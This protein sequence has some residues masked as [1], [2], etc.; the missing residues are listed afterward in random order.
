VIT[1][2]MTFNV[3][4]RRASRPIFAGFE[5]DLPF[6]VFFSAITPL[7]KI[8]YFFFFNSLLIFILIIY[9]KIRE[10]PHFESMRLCRTL[11]K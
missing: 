1:R 10:E 11:S 8:L 5:A 7:V 9:P 2:K 4:T 3:R 6:V